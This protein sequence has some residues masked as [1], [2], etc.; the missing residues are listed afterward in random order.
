MRPNVFKKAAPSVKNGR[1]CFESFCFVLR[2][3]R[4]KICFVKKRAHFLVRPLWLNQIYY[5][6][7]ETV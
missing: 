5:A 7:G 4:L 2:I 1:R 6:I 3:A